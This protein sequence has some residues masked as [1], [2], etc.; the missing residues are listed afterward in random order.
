MSAHRVLADLHR[1]NVFHQ[2]ADPGDEAVMDTNGKSN[3]ILVL[4]SA[5]TRLLPTHGQPGDTIVVVN[6]SG[7]SV[8]VEDSAS[9]VGLAVGN[10]LV[11]TFKATGS[12]TSATAWVGTVHTALS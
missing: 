11:C 2:I 9:A 8:N 1:A 10:N 12:T 4:E 6:R 3:V 5:G 7:G